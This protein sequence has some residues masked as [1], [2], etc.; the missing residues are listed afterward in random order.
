MATRVYVEIEPK[1]LII[2]EPGVFMTIDSNLFDL[3]EDCKVQG[4]KAPMQLLS[5]LKSQELR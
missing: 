2:L 5:S 3:G 1:S 4:G